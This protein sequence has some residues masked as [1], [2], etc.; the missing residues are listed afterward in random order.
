MPP[1][2]PRELAQSL[3]KLV[4]AAVRLE[5]Q[6]VEVRRRD[7][8]VTYGVEQ[9]DLFVVDK[10]QREHAVRLDLSMREIAKAFATEGFVEP[11]L[12]E[13]ES[14]RAHA[15]AIALSNVHA[16]RADL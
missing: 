14:I 3:R 11:G 16:L 15:F 13:I 9:V 8:Q 5:W 1:I 2:D 10:R 12:A 6:K 4:P 7:D